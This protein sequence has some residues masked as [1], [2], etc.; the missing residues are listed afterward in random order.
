MEIQ[1]KEAIC[2]KA[3]LLLC[4]SIAQVSEA[5]A[6]HDPNAA[7]ITVAHRLT[8]AGNLLSRLFTGK[9]E[10]VCHIPPPNASGDFGNLKF[11]AR[12]RRD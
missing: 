5:F 12:V 11:C 6:Q 2:T 8:R 10:I 1:T 9:T 3:V 4:V 7:T